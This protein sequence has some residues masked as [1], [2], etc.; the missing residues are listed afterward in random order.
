VPGLGEGL[1]EAFWELAGDALGRSWGR[2]LGCLGGG[3][4]V[5]LIDTVGVVLGPP[6]GKPDSE[7][8]KV[9]LSLKSLSSVATSFLDFS[10]FLAD[11]PALSRCGK[12][13][14]STGKVVL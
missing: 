5:G 13:F 7:V 3:F 6:A 14:E 12:A 10:T 4:A 2:G 11:L 9:N 8:D 1:G